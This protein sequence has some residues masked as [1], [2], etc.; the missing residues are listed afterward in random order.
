VPYCRLAALLQQCLA[1]GR[2]HTRFVGG[3]RV[4]IAGGKRNGRKRDRNETNDFSETELRD[5]II[6][7]CRKA[8]TYC[9]TTKRHCCAS[10]C[11]EIRQRIGAR[12]WLHCRKGTTNKFLTFCVIDLSRAGKFSVISNRFAAREYR[13]I[14]DDDKF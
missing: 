1:V 9:T 13:Q 2:G 4:L 3:N 7:R 5:A 6:R 8:R 14:C 11:G 12:P 10:P